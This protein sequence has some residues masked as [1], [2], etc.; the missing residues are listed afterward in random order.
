M[1]KLFLNILTPIQFQVLI[2]AAILINHHNHPYAFSQAPASPLL[3]T[4]TSSS[5]LWSQNEPPINFGDTANL[6]SKRGYNQRYSLW[7]K[8]AESVVEPPRDVFNVDTMLEYLQS[9]SLLRVGIPAFL[10]AGIMA[11]AYTPLSKVIGSLSGFDHDGVYLVVSQDSSQYLQNILTTCG[12][13]FTII[14]GYTY[15]F[16][17]QQQE[18]IFVALF[19][20][21]SE[22]KSLLEQV[23]LVLQGRRSSYISVLN[24]IEK[25]V[26]EDLKCVNVEPAQLLSARPADDPLES[27]MFY[28]SVGEPSIVYE[29]IQSLR[30]ARARRLGGFQQ[31]CPEIH[32]ILLY[33]LAF[34]VLSVFPVLGAG[35]QVIGGDGILHVQSF[36]FGIMVFGIVTVLGV[37][38][39]LRRPAG[40][41]Y[42]TD[43]LISIM[44][45]GLEEELKM[46][47]NYL[48]TEASEESPTVDR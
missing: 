30:R 33:T 44:S 12:L 40:G 16:M 14:V 22:T 10:Y 6:S 13:M 39:E 29:T 9:I 47:L 43:V 25:Y 20:E 4:F 26:N 48:S 23:S 24:C 38:N 35:V 36:Y 18:H 32:M 2:C 46:R 11:L 5:R 21:V 7:H 42:N 17:Y 27:I 8:M 37:I 45:Q 15:Y 1:K 31:K 3:P 34:I 28:T 41:V 19:D